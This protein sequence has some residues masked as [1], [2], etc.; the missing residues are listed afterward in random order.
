MAL[1]MLSTVIKRKAVGPSFEKCFGGYCLNKAIE[2][3]FVQTYK[4]AYKFTNRHWLFT[5]G[6]FL[7]V[8]DIE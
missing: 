8:I 3:L 2:Y 1:T 7:C 6:G 5:F 4:V